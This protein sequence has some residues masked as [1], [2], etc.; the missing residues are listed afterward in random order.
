MTIFPNLTTQSTPDQLAA[1][2]SLLKSL[3]RLSSGAA[4]APTSGAET[5]ADA[6]GAPG[7][8]LNARAVEL[9]T[10]QEHVGNAL[11]LTQTR[12][13]YL[14]QIGASFDRMGELAASAQNEQVT[15]YERGLYQDE[16]AQLSSGISSLADRSYNHGGVF[17][18]TSVSVSDAGNGSVVL[19]GV[20]FSQPVYAEALQ[21]RIDSVPNARAAAGK[22]DLART[23]LSADGAM[24]ENDRA[25]L[26]AAADRLAVSRENFHAIAS[27]IREPDSAEASTQFARETIVSQPNTALRAQA[28]AT[29]QRALRLLP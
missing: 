14:H 6:V 17:A 1:R 13:A 21:A 26:N 20:D 2:E 15:P 22:V 19:A 8:G 27:P 29:P 9:E 24:I 3:S 11:S 4:A 18:E 25:T 12:Q 23:Q 28:N 5:D 7:L 10:A 16:Y